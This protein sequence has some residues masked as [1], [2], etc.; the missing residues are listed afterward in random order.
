MR[1]LVSLQGL[2]H[3][4]AVARKYFLLQILGFSEFLLCIHT[5]LFVAYRRNDKCVVILNAV[6][7]CVHEQLPPK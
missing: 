3:K 2:F 5:D 4:D 6:Q 7:I 1:V